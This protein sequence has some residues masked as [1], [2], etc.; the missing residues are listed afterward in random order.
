MLWLWSGR[1]FFSVPRALADFQPSRALLCGWQN[2]L[3][4]CSELGRGTDLA[5]NF[6]RTSCANAAANTTGRWSERGE[7]GE[8]AR[9]L[10]GRCRCSLCARGQPG[11]PAACWSARCFCAPLS[12]RNSWVSSWVSESLKTLPLHRSSWGWGRLPLLLARLPR[13]KDPS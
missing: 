1:P 12:K 9:P 13:V 3:L 5:I 11:L 6:V 7:W 2:G 8:I 4:L 10:P